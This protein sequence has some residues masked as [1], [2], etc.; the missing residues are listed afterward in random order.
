MPNDYITIKALT[1][2][3]DS[4]LKGGKIDK[5]TM[6]EKDEINLFVRANN[7]N[8]NLAISCNA[9]NPRIHLTTIKKQSP[10]VALAF[11]MHLRKYLL[12]GNIEKIYTLNEDRIIVIEVKSRNEMRDIVSYRLIAEMMGRYSNIILVNEKDTITDA[13]KQ[14]P[15]DVMTKRTLV[16]SAKYSIPEQ[17][18][19]KLSQVD[20][21]KDLLVSYTGTSISQMLSNNISGI[22]KNTAQEIV[23][24]ANVEDSK[25]NLDSDDI[26]KIL[27]S[28][29]VF[30]NIYDSKIYSPCVSI[31]NGTAHD[32]YATKYS[33]INEYKK[34]KTL[35][36]AVDN[37]LS[38]KDDEYRQQEKTKY[39]LKAYNALMGKCKKRLEKS[40]QRLAEASSKET[41]RIYGELI[42][43]NI[44][45]IKK[46]DDK[47]TVE[48][49]YD[50][51]NEITIKLDETLA[52]QANAQN[53]FKKYTKLKHTEEISLEQIEE[54]EDTIAYLTTIEPYI[55][56]AKTPQEILELQRELENVGALKASR[57]KGNKKPVEAPPIHYLYKGYH[58]YVGKNNLQNDKLT[59][60]VAN[61]GDIW[62]HTKAFHG[63]HTIIVLD[64]RDVTDDVIKFAAEVCAFYSDCDNS[65]KVEVDYTQRKNVKRHP[66]KNPGMVL[67]EVY[68]SANITPNEH[69]DCL[70][71]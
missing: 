35:N 22:A 61:G 68:K 8:Y 56:R 31:V 11:C 49:Y 70:V 29:D 40:N 10:I 48:N 50:N 13:L 43:A 32:F 9:S 63:S 42:T 39:L 55:H 19:I 60:K 5:I 4:S 2:E 44:Y 12:N 7:T 23:N 37:C 26:E 57:Q 30:N 15:F 41:Y 24:Y 62:L 46:G 6:P 58:I 53:Y 33:T 51:N 14:V 36:E 25:Q 28:L 20:K 47:V 66:N 34:Y 71:K 69:K 64:G 16:P 65:S 21:I 18:K 3:L 1:K 67:Y 59:F 52:P 27:N 17:P 54:L 45:K 38:Q